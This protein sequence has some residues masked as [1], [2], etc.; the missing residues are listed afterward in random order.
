VLDVV[1]VRVE[2]VAVVELP[3]RPP[4]AQLNSGGFL[5]RGYQW[6]VDNLLISAKTFWT[7]ILLFPLLLIGLAFVYDIVIRASVPDSEYGFDHRFHIWLNVFVNMLCLSSL[8]Y[9]GGDLRRRL[10]AAIVGVMV[11]F[12]LL[13]FV[14]M[15]FRLYYSRPVLI[16]SAL[17]TVTLVTLLSL[18]LE[19][20]RRRRIGII[21]QGIDEETREKVGPG[22]EFVQSPMEAAR[23]YDMVLV[24]WT[25]ITDPKWMQFAQNAIL[26]RCEVRHVAFF[27]ETRHGRVLPEYFEKDHATTRASSLYL[28][29]YKR[30]FDTAL[31]LLVLP[32][33]LVIV[34]IASLLILV[35]M[36]RPILFVQNRLGING[37]TFKM[38][39]LRSMHSAP[40]TAGASAT[41]VNDPRVT[42]LGKF[43]RRLRID[44]LPQFYNILIGDMSLVGPRPEQP[45]LAD[46]YAMKLPAFQSRTMLRP[47][48]TGWAQVRGEYASNEKETEDK[49]AYD[50]Y[51]LKYASFTTD[52]S[53]L[54]QTFKT[55]LTGNSAR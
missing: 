10:E 42:R 11:N 38:Y 17:A 15:A 46:T 54:V 34:A 29:L 41:A 20:Y 24:D 37:Q 18:L 16:V 47:G 52:L 27:I 9:L 25:K 30:I 22:A 36:G 12:A 51:Y 40:A 4:N 33:A 13:L 44:E 35:T 8:L 26:S 2:F 39:K 31:I 19:K 21:P 6:A 3:F 53:I 23:S 50:L 14:I 55:L 28:N 43:L 7:I 32:I 48:I 45:E 1:L 5:A 49:L